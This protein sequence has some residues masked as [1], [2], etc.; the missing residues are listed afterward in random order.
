MV[1]K[2]PD[3]NME[4]VNTFK[5]WMAQIRANFIILAVFLVIIGLAFSLKYPPGSGTSLNIFHAFLLVIGVALSHIS[6]NLFNEYSDF[7]TKID[8]YT[9]R[10]PFSG[11][12]GMLTTGKTRPENVR[13]VGITA[14]VIAAAIGCYFAIVSHWIIIL[15]SLIPIAIQ[16]INEFFKAVGLSFELPIL[17]SSF[18]VIIVVV[19]VFVFG[20]LSYRRWGLVRSKGKITSNISPGTFLMYKMWKEIKD[21]E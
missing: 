18:F 9:R 3:P 19:V 13:Q 15:F 7:K 2:L 10:T 21:K 17:F 14:L 5:I 12:S 4:K 1:Q 6:V 8:Y 11:G 20:L 16:N